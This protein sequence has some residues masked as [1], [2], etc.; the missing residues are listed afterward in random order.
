VRKAT[1]ALVGL[2]GL[3]VL[4]YS[5]SFIE[6]FVSGIEGHPGLPSCVSSH[7]Q[8]GAQQAIENSPFARTSGLS[9]LA[10]TEVKKI[11]ANAQKVE[12][13][14]MAIL[15]SGQKGTVSYTFTNDPSFGGG[16]YYIQASLDLA[17]FKPYP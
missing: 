7:G 4:L 9:V 1:I 8:S 16:R 10:I 13:K 15:S 3:G 17:G 14:A 5:S 11:S 12:C 2:A 6:G